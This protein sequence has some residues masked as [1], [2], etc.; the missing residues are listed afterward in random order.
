MLG[1][2]DMQ[3]SVYIYVLLYINTFDKILIFIY[4]IN[5]Y[6]NIL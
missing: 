3:Y 2:K 5:V 4:L 1:L 6:I